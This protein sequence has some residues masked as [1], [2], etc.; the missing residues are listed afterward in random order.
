VDIISKMHEAVQLFETTTA[1]PS[2]RVGNLREGKLRE[3]NL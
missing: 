2:R 3:G 1:L